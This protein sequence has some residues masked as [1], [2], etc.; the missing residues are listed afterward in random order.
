MLLMYMEGHSLRGIGLAFNK[1][2][3]TVGRIIKRYL[4]GGD[5]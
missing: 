3:P 1:S 2:H 4:G 5:A